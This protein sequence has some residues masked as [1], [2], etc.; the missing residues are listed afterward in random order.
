MCMTSDDDTRV[1]SRGVLVSR[2]RATARLATALAWLVLGASLSACQFL[3]NE[4][5]F[6]DA[7]HPSTPATEQQG[8]W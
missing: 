1:R 5:F 6:L 3:Q 4:F 8:A 2:R 7:A